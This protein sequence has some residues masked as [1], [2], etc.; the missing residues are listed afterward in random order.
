[1]AANSRQVATYQ[2]GQKRAEEDA[3][4][5][6]TK[7]GQAAR[8]PGRRVEVR[9]L[10]PAR[11][12]TEWVRNEIDEVDCPFPLSGALLIQNVVNCLTILRAGW[13]A[14]RSHYM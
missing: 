11:L 6:L 12:V 1:M 9:P 7:K 10:S 13:P 2:L 4:H 5:A 14:L 3:Q 8:S